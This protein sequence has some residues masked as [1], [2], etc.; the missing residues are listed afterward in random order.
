[1]NMDDDMGSLLKKNNI[2]ARLIFKD[3]TSSLRLM[4][5]RI[6]FRN[7][8]SKTISFFSLKGHFSRDIL[9]LNFGFKGY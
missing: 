6:Y 5:I 7:K 3:S 2:Q 9:L 1:M 8:I 4:T